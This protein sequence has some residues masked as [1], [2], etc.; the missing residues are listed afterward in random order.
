MNILNL[1]G[2]MSEEEI[3]LDFFK[4]SNNVAGLIDSLLNN[5]RKQGV[6]FEPKEFLAPGAAI[7]CAVAIASGSSDRKAL[8]HNIT[9][10][11]ELIDL[12]AKHA[13]KKLE[14]EYQP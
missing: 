9:A 5:A 7:F 3:M 1:I 13:F 4:R 10:M 12:Q 14:E 6:A 8:E 11:Q 2:D